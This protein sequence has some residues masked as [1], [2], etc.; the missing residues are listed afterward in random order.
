MKDMK[1]A[2]LLL[3]LLFISG[4]IT[5]S[6]VTNTPI[7]TNSIDCSDVQPLWWGKKGTPPPD[8]SWKCQDW[9]IKK[10]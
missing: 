2:Y 9:I 8:W 3:V 10:Q 1:K 4:C 6:E 5:T 7:L